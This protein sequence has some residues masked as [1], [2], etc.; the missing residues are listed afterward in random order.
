M[1]LSIDEELLERARELGSLGSGRKPNLLGGVSAED[2]W[3][4][5]PNCSAM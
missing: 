3:P 5:R 4:I 1:K 2:D